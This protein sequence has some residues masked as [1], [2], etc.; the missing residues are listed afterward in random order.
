MCKGGLLGSLACAVWLIPVAGA[1]AGCSR[2]PKE[3][4]D[5]LVFAAASLAGALGDIEDAFEESGSAGVTISYGGSQMLAQ[6]IASGAPADV[7]IS[8]GG[9]PVDF[10]DRKGMLEP[11]RADILA[12]RLVVVVRSSAVLQIDSLQQLRAPEMRRIAIAEPALAPA[13]RYA[14]ESLERLGL[15][16]ALQPKMVFGADVRATLAYVESGNADAALVYATD[17]RAARSIRVLD[18]VPQDSYSGVVYPA[19]VVK[20]R[21]SKTAALTFLDFLRSPTS[22]EIFR[23]YGFEPVQ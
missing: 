14:R 11:E 16:D 19:A 10:L 12:N 5:L 8:A 13:G 2:A 3:P 6:Q 18:I 4:Q 21:P 17:A 15:W 23:V 9:P 20:G 7:I 1:M 22:R